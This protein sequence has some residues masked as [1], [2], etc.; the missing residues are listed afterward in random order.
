MTRAASIKSICECSSLP[1]DNNDLANDP[2][3][4]ALEQQRDINDDQAR[5]F[6]PEFEQPLQDLVPDGWVN[7]GIG[8]PSL[9]WV[10]KDDGTKFIPIQGLTHFLILQDFDSKMSYELLV[11]RMCRLDD[12]TRQFVAVN[13]GDVEGNN[14]GHDRGFS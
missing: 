3:Q 11:S 13:D 12:N 10:R 9:G 2:P 8:D 4:L 5:S 6:D 7:D 14:R 1:V